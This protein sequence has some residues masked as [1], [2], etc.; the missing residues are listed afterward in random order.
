MC[1][2]RH[3]TVSSHSLTHQTGAPGDGAAPAVTETLPPTTTGHHHGGSVEERQK[4]CRTRMGYS[5][6]AVNLAFQA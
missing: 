6:Y 5:R 1:G 2:I 4:L 3:L